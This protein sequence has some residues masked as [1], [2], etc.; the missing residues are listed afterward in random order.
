MSDTEEFHE[1]NEENEEN[2]QYDE[3]EDEVYEQQF[4]TGLESGSKGQYVRPISG[5]RPTGILS[6][7][8]FNPQ[9]NKWWSIFKV[10]KNIYTTNEVPEDKRGILS[11]YA[12]KLNLD[13]KNVFML[14]TAILIAYNMITL[15]EKLTKKT[16][17]KHIERLSEYIGK[18]IKNTK[19]DKIPNIFERYFISIFNHLNFVIENIP[20]FKDLIPENVPSE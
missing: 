17:I 12:A 4:V 16:Y 7:K 6:S 14:A 8:N 13:H 18:D 19:S 3:D 5:N 11:E 2:E 9:D 10:Y 20:D 1:E 15:H